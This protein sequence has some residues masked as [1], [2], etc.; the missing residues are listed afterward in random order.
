MSAGFAVGETLDGVKNRNIGQF[1]L[2]LY[3]FGAAATPFLSTAAIAPWVPVIA[4]EAELTVRGAIEVNKFVNE[5]QRQHNF[6]DEEWSPGQFLDC[7]SRG[8][9]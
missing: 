7:F 3:H 2:G 9:L 5:V 8:C 6:I 4:A 1:G